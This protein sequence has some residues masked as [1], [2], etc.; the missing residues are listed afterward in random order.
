MPTFNFKIKKDVANVIDKKPDKNIGT[1][2]TNNVR[3]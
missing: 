3:L 2:D 1:I